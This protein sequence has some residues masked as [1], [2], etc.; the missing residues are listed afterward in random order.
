MVLVPYAGVEGLNA[1]TNVPIRLPMPT[2]GGVMI[3]ADGKLMAVP[4]GIAS[5]EVGVITFAVPAE[6]TTTISVAA[7]TMTGPGAPGGTTPPTP[8]TRP[9]GRAPEFPA[10]ELTESGFLSAMEEFLGAGYTEVTPGSGRYVS[11]DGLRQVR[12]GAHETSGPRHHAH[13]EAYDRP[14]GQGG[15][16]I[17]NSVVNI[18]AD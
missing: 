2:A 17:E 16:V 12:Y 10:G 7:M 18:I 11:A 1:L 9:A 6:V 3:Q 15:R 14:A 13:F 8:P 5:A 4:R